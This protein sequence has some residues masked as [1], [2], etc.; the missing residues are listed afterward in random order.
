MESIRNQSNGKNEQFLS[1]VS[2]FSSRILCTEHTHTHAHKKS[3]VF[4]PAIAYIR[5]NDWYML[6]TCVAPV[7]FCQ[8]E[9][10]IYFLKLLGNS[11]AHRV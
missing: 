3:S 8:N 10:R 9:L 2:T 1:D 6:R 4:L 5:S 7:V 11:N